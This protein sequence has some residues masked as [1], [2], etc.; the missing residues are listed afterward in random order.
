MGNFPLDHI[1]HSQG[2]FPDFFF[3]HKLQYCGYRTH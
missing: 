2:Y 3:K 1:I